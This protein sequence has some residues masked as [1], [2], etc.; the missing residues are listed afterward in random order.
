M[1]QKRSA[2]GLSLPLL[3]SCQP[4]TRWAAHYTGPAQRSRGGGPHDVR[5]R[6]LEFAGP[7]RLALVDLEL[8]PLRSGEVRVRALYSGI[9]S[10]T[11]LLAY[12]GE[13]DPDLP[14]DESIGTLGGTFSYPFRY[15]YSSVGIVESSRSSLPEG[16]SVFVFHPH[17]D[18]FH[19]S[20]E[21]AIELPDVEARVATLFP[22]VETALQ[23]KLDAGDVT[24]DHVVVMG[25]GAIG[26]LT[27]WLLRAGGADV[28]GV[29]PDRKRRDLASELDI[30]AIDTLS[31]A[32]HVSEATSGRGVPLVVEASGNP[33]ALRAA[34][35]LLAH[36]GSALVASWYG[37]KWVTLPL[38]ADFHRRRLSIRSTQVSSI[39]ASLRARWSLQRRREHAARLLQVLPL[40]R[41]ATHE[42]PFEEAPQ[43]FA[44]LDE[45]KRGIVH[46]ALR[47]SDA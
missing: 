7:H 9:S 44:A 22:L 40:K 24:G 26:V 36:E 16:T 42:W 28:V 13:V 32:A 37:T 27:A 5:A 4:N 47:Y 34:L 17:Q 23:I 45:G 1:F 38:G 39:P 41:L 3:T 18:R 14:L 21:A 12:R 43:A 33:E 6:A 20:A 46:V 2:V 19:C 30:A 8:P 25:L 35:P 15:G 29:D 11:E 31:M 10:G